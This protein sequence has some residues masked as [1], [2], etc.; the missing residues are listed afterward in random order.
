[1]IYQQ[2]YYSYWYY[3]NE[4][5]RPVQK[6]GINFISV[7]LKKGTNNITIFFNPL[8]IKAGMIISLLSFLSALF[9]L[10]FISRRKPI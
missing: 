5:S 2:N 9:L 3:D 8:K 4:G 1:M 6:A 7:P 10:L